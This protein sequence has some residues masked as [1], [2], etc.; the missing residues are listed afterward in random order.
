MYDS[1]EAAG[2]WMGEVCETA[3]A[4]GIMVVGVCV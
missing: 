3:V 1:L 4:G 2:A